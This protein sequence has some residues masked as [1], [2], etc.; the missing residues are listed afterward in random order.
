[1]G[2]LMGPLSP[3][4]ICSIKKEFQLAPCTPVS[5]RH[6]TYLWSGQWR[7][8]FA[9][10]AFALARRDLD[11]TYRGEIEPDNSSMKNSEPY[12]RTEE[13]TMTKVISETTGQ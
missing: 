3:S 7:T 8:T 10:Q 5:L 6:T 2:R 4:G 12:L 9:A 13:T 1:M 11:V